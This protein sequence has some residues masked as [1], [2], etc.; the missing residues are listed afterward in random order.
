MAVIQDF[1]VRKGLAVT[2]NATVT[3]NV[4]ISQQ[5][6]VTNAT[7]LANTL[8]VTGAATFSNT[9]TTTG[10]ANV[11]G[12]LQVVGA[13]AFG[14]S[15]VTFDTDTLVVDAVNDRL[16]I[17]AASSTVALF[18]QGDANVSGTFTAANISFT[19]ITGTSLTMTT[20]NS[21]FDSGVLFVD[22]TNN[23]VGINNTTPDAS[24]TITGTANVA[25][26]LRVGGTTTLASTLGVTGAA[27][28]SNTI[29]VT[30]N[31]TFS[32]TIAVTGAATLSST[33]GVTG[34]ATFS[35]TVG[36]TGALTATGGVVGSLNGVANQ[37]GRTVTAGSFLVG[38]GTLTGDITLAVNATS[39]STG[40]TVVAR[41]ASGNFN[42]GTITA[43]LS[44]VATSA[45][46]LLYAGA[47]RSATDGN[48]GN[49]IVARDASG[50]FS[51]GI[52]SGTATAARYADLAELYLADKDYPV[53]TV[54]KVG[55]EKEIT[56]HTA[57][58]YIRAL[59]T[60]SDKPAFLMNKDLKG[61]VAVALKGR[62]PVRVI[63]MVKKGQGL[64]AS[65]I[66]G[67]ATTNNI[68]YFAIALEDYLA[69]EEGLIE[70][71]IL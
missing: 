42:A 24:I 61:G 4:A 70:A 26:A 33:I 36:V 52:M 45:N 6:S 55:G 8:A 30:G 39:L 51:A 38:G 54:V 69:Y 46:T 59:G 12:S 18:V 21:N 35:N 48:T 49:S 43:S 67:V 7:S 65:A 34:A 71:V 22:G 27:T 66:P 1:R 9:L 13:G 60:I 62:V 41:D 31:A 57:L 37:C 19:N 53:G 32:N 40:S 11:G 50:N 16:S 56:E 25:A 15:N 44:G 58:D 20:G 47:Y 5:L 28:L 64:G 68:S 10:F 23:R 2:E 17:N 63:G 29:A 14:T 3:G